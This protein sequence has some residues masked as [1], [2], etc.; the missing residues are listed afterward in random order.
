[1]RLR[2]LRWYILSCIVLI[3]AYAA[4]A[5][6]CY[7]NMVKSK[8]R[9]SMAELSKEASNSFSEV[10]TSSI[11]SYY[12][13]YQ[14]V[15]SETYYTITASEVIVSPDT[16]VEDTYYVLEDGN[17]Y[18]SNEYSATAKYYTIASAR[19]DDNMT[20]EE[21][22]S[23]AYYVMEGQSFIR[24]TS[25][26]LFRKVIITA[27]ESKFVGI[28]G[29]KILLARFKDFATG[30]SS[31]NV[32]YYFF[33]L[34]TVDQ[35]NYECSAVSLKNII[36]ST[37]DTVN[38]E[39]LYTTLIF[40]S[41]GIIYNYS[42][43]E[44][45]NGMLI[46]AKLGSKFDFNSLVKKDSNLVWDIDGVSYVIT[47]APLFSA[48]VAT[49]IPLD[50]AYFS[51][52]WINGQL[53]VFYIIG[54]VILIGMLVILILGCKKSSQLL[55]V[56]RH[57]LEAT[58]S[59]VIRIDMEGKIIFTNK[60]FKQLYGITKLENVDN[61]I[62]VDR[63]APILAT[64]KEN[65]PFECSLPKNDDSGDLYYFQF[66]PIKILSSIYLMG[67]EITDD[68]NRRK[69]LYLMN[70]RNEITNIDNNFSFVNDYTT[71]VKNAGTYDLAFVQYNICKHEEIV[72]VFGR[73]NF[74]TLLNEF[75]NIVH[76][77]YEGMRI[78]QLND[79]KFIVVVPNSDLE[80]VTTKINE[81]LDILRRPIQIKQN[82]IYVKVKVTI[83][84][85][86]NGT[87][88]VTVEEIKQKLDLAYRNIADF[89]TKDFILY[90]PAMDGVIE[91]AD[92]MEKD[93]VN[94]L[95]NDEF[96]M[97]LQPQFDVIHNRIDGFES[98][99]RWSNPKYFDKSPQ[100]FVELAEQRG[101]IL[102]IGRYVI[103]ETFRLA[104]LLEDWNVHISMNVSPIQLLQVGFVQQIID[105]YK[106]LKLKPGAIAIEI[107]ETFLMGNFSLMKEKL[108]RLKEEG[109][110]I[111][112]DDFCTGYS[113]MLY[114][115]DLPVDTLK[116][117]KE[118]TKYV[119]NNKVHASIVKTI[120]ELGVSLDMDIICEGVETEEQ[121]DMVKKFGAR[122]IQGFLIS[123]AVPYEQALDLLDKYNTKKR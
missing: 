118:F 20:E 102:D 74:N 3:I 116:I 107:T 111:H 72:A 106:S 65:R 37:Y 63:G 93:L 47:A 56:D 52:D 2:D 57:S 95:A 6:L 81:S 9:T 90:E 103:K 28:E 14:E 26:S 60:T 83:Y 78:Y 104:K 34:R 54:L 86:K 120:C 84:N 94:G 101:Y 33:F 68:Y 115:K 18:I 117:D 91:A 64:A 58:K 119:T 100:A 71:L 110:Q 7:N 85:L 38:N 15:G 45:A 36:N 75:A 108:K 43:D 51:I 12:D 97:Y 27:P 55:R 79:D 49:F 46:S 23:N 76:S 24:D 1:M 4:I 73:T 92:E 44:R 22:N 30:T 77:S 67:S 39:Y 8:V 121:K 88:G 61:F 25:F 105:E 62:D 5:L 109:F 50:S 89:S 114:L 13:T 122:L 41:E 82:H 35:Y 11:N 31:T 59:I 96:R 123:K 69:Y 19:A 16:F 112:L 98:L 99:I 87:E 32:D 53:A 48:Y 42:K 40:N 113:S 70:G 66:T 29:R 17:Y 21:F 80:E 10:A